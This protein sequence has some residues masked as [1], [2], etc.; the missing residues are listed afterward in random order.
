MLGFPEQM[1]LLLFDG[2]KFVAIPARLLSFALAG[3]VLMELALANRIDTDPERLFVVDGAPLH[4]DLLDPPLA[5]IVAA[6]RTHDTRYWIEQMVPH[7]PAVRDRCLSR[8]IERA[9][10]RRDGD[11]FAWVASSGSETRQRLVAVLRRNEIPS[12]RDIVL[13]ALAAVCGIFRGTLSDDEYEELAP[14]IRQIARMDLIARKVAD[15]VRDIEATVSLP[16]V[17]MLRFRD[18]QA[19]RWQAP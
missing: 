13:I 1:L 17:P 5:R 19:T 9:I 4:D 2:G 15:A 11:R 8:L 3:S 10:L 16:R 12:D 14:R 7:A 6:N 18:R